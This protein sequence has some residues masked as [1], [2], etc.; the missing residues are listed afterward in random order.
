M[1]F[2]PA[3]LLDEAHERSNSSPRADHDHR[4]GGFE[5]QAELRLADVHG[6]GGLVPIVRDQFVFQPIGRNSLVGAA[7]LGL[8]LDHDGADVDAVGMNLH[9]REELITARS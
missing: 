5:R 1:L 8:V 6:D 4:V 9:K 2:E 3:S 7:S